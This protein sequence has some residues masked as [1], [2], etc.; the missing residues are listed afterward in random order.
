MLR[1]KSLM[2]R[3]VFLHILAVGLAAIFLPL[4]LFWLLNS[5]IDNLHRAAMRDNVLLE[6]V[7]ERFHSAEDYLHK[8]NH[9]MNLDE[10]K[11]G[12]TVK[13]PNVL[14]FKIEDLQ[15][16]WDEIQKR[17]F[18]AGGLFDRLSRAGR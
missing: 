4:V 6:F 14:P 12:D 9:P 10:L 17:N 1:F 11:P 7:A 8:L 3:I 2:S 18:D 13:A 15:G 16:S 5:E